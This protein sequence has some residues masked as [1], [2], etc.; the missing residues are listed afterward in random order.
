MMT[1]TSYGWEHECLAICSRTCHLFRTP[2]MVELILQYLQNT[3]LV[4]LHSFREQK[5]FTREFW[6]KKVRAAGRTEVRKGPIHRSN[7]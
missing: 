4:G 1:L 6:N 5:C 7:E 3:W 2:D